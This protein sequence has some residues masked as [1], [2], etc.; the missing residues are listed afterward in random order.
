MSIGLC[1]LEKE[2]SEEAKN[3]KKITF[4]PQKPSFLS[5]FSLFQNFIFQLAQPYMSTLNLPVNTTW[6]IDGWHTIYC[7]VR[8]RVNGLQSY[9]RTA[10][11]PFS[12]VER[13]RLSVA[14]PP[15]GPAYCHICLRL[16]YSCDLVS[17]PWPRP[18][19]NTSS[20]KNRET[21]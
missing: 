5:I 11:T 18:V 10:Q 13:S 3:A 9:I 19:S 7:P 6:P 1:S 8:V 21:E 14:V 15:N 16:S 2:S 12:V 4:L 20:N 17:W